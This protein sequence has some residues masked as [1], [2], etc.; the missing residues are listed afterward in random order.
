MTRYVVMDLFHRLDHLSVDSWIFLVEKAT[1]TFSLLVCIW[2]GRSAFLESLLVLFCRPVSILC[3]LADEMS[4]ACNAI[5]L[6]ETWQV[7]IDFLV[8]QLLCLLGLHVFED[9]LI[10]VWRAAICLPR[11]SVLLV[12]RHVSASAHCST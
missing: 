3:D 6:T 1:S 12:S 8:L 9:N 4:C 11:F 7:L 5:E 10:Y 2:L